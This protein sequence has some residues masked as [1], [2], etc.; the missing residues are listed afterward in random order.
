MGTDHLR[1]RKSGRCSTG[2]CVEVAHV[3]AAVHLRDSEDPEGPRLTFAPTSWAAFLDRLRA[4]DFD[5]A[6]PAAR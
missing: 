1:W 3:P 2:G 6:Q 4:G 5:L